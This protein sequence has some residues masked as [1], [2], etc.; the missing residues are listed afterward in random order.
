LAELIC[1]H[2]KHDGREVARL[3][4][5]P[6][7]ARLTHLALGYGIRGGELWRKLARSNTVGRFHKLRFGFA[8]TDKQLNALLDNPEVCKVG[9]LALPHRGKIAR[10]TQ[11]RYEKV[12]GVKVTRSSWA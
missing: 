12:F 1:E 7:F 11:R 8:I 4:D 5:H 3:I 6:H 2:G 9:R 10:G